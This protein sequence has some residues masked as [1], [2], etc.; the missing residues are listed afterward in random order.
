MTYPADY[1]LPDAVL[2]H[3]AAHGL[4]EGAGCELDL[5]EWDYRK[6]QRFS[7]SGMVIPKIFGFSIRA[8]A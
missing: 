2:E 1:G 7:S 4:V 3:L 8:S 6:Y 5:V